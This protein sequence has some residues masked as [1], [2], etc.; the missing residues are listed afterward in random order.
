MIA[1]DIQYGSHIESVEN[2]E[3]V[4]KGENVDIVL[5]WVSTLSNLFV[6]YR[7]VDAHL[8]LTRAGY[9]SAVGNLWEYCSQLRYG[10]LLTAAKLLSSSVVR[11]P[12][13]LLRRSSLKLFPAPARS[14][15]YCRQDYGMYTVATVPCTWTLLQVPR[16]MPCSWQACW[17]ACL[18][19]Q[20]WLH[21]RVQ[22]SRSA[23]KSVVACE[24]P[25]IEGTVLTE[26]SAGH[27]VC[28]MATADICATLTLEERLKRAMTS[29]QPSLHETRGTSSWNGNG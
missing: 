4:R 9:G 23:I 15:R 29:S 19:A 18:E 17:S 21:R 16:R 25:W 7:I 6:A 20:Q 8:G 12:A 28:I 24:S 22:G 27:I 3:D 14:S 10:K 5:K 26:H 13:T 11:R 1:I 2:S